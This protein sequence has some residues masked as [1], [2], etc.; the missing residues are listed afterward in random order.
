MNLKQALETPQARAVYDAVLAEQYDLA[1]GRDPAPLPTPRGDG[2]LGTLVE[3]MLSE[4]TLSHLR[5]TAAQHVAD[6]IEHMRGVE[7]HAER[8][9]HA[10]RT[11]IDN[12]I[13]TSQAR[14][15]GRPRHISRRGGALLEAMLAPANEDARAQASQPRT[16]GARVLDDLRATS[17]RST[18]Y[19]GDEIV[20]DPH[21][22]RLLEAPVAAI[23]PAERGWR[24]RLAI[25]GLSATTIEAL[26]GVR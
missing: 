5:E 14:R 10:N 2:G 16:R 13:A 24:E 3:A 25:R 23:P 4:P 8:R 9:R 1:L 6:R 18:P 26:G 22:G 11:Q 19:D 12:A 17:L 15:G 21:S 20:R 7:L